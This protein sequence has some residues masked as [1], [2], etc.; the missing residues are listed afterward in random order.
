MQP[1]NVKTIAILGGSFNPPTLAHAASL[2]HAVK[3][4]GAQLGLFVPSSDLY[5]DHKW[6]KHKAT[7]PAPGVLPFTTRMTMCRTYANQLTDEHTHFSVSNAEIDGNRYGNTFAMLEKVQLQWPGRKLLFV[8]GDDKLGI[9]PKWGNIDKLLSKYEMLV[10]P[11]QNGSEDEITS[12]ITDSPVLEPFKD[13]FTIL[14]PL[15]DEGLC[16]VSS[17]WFWKAAVKNNRDAELCYVNPETA[18]MVTAWLK[19]R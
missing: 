8:I 12:A 9:L 11:R 2:G 4:S 15:T 13:R 1:K 10:I 18:D 7:N 17:T 6:Q 5:V 19:N 14:P 3:H 16:D